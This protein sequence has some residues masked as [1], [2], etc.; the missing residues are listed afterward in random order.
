MWLWSAELHEWGFKRKSERY[1]RCER[2][3]GLGDQAHISIFA[4]S[5]QTSDGKKR[6]E[7]DA[8]HITFNL[9]LEHVHFY[10][11]ERDHHEWEPGGHTSCGEIR[12][13]GHDPIELRDQADRIALTLIEVMGGRFHSR[14]EPC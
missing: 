2:R 14:E 3:F 9:R 1:W 13:L 4:W 5:E 11:H 10:Y 6:V 7:I 12:R 8:F